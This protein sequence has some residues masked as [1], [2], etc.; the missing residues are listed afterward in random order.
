MD[1]ARD[2]RYWIEVRPE[3]AGENAEDDA[4]NNAFQKGI[5]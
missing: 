1:H 2:D 4:V 5:A 3:D